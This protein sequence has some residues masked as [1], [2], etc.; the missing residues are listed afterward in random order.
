MHGSRRRADGVP[1]R[2]S[3]FVGLYAF[4][5]QIIPDTDSS[6]ERLYSYGRPLL[7]H[8]IQ[9][10][11]PVRLGDNMEHPLPQQPPLLQDRV[12]RAATTASSTPSQPNNPPPDS[13]RRHRNGC[14]RAVRAMTSLAV[15]SST[16]G[17]GALWRHVDTIGAVTSL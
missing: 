3:A 7:P 16:P 12:R 13:D 5:S 1:D 4:V 11:A 10:R 2:L 8:L 17:R 9:D 14:R 6:L 15:A